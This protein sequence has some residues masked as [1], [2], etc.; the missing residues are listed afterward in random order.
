MMIRTCGFAKN[1]ALLTTGL[2]WFLQLASLQSPLQTVACRGLL[3]NTAAN[4]HKDPQEI[5]GTGHDGLDPK[6]PDVGST[7]LS[8]ICPSKPHRR[9][10]E[11]EAKMKGVSSGQRARSRGFMLG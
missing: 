5:L 10:E 1:K 9:A 4:L 7:S 11:V 8:Q 6:D 2:L 3:R